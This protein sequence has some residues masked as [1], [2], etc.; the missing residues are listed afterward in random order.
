MKRPGFNAPLG[1]AVRI[2]GFFLLLQLVE[3]RAS[4]YAEHLRRAGPVAPRLCQR[5]LDVRPFYFLPGLVEAEPAHPVLYR[6]PGPG[7]ARKLVD[8][9]YVFGVGEYYRPFDDVLEL[10]HVAR[11]VVGRE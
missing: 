8:P 4:A 2:S 9:C 10:P 1:R 3:E 6:R 7:A 5:P 11:P